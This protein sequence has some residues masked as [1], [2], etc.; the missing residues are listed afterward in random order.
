[1]RAGACAALC[2]LVGC[3]ALEGLGDLT[4]DGGGGGPS[5]ALAGDDCNAPPPPGWAGPVALYEGAPGTLPSC[6]DVYSTPVAQGKRGATAPPAQCGACACGPAAVTC[7]PGSLDVFWKSSC[8][9]GS[10]TVDLPGGMCTGVPGMTGM[11]YSYGVAAPSVT[12]G[13]APSGGVPSLPATAWTTAGIACAPA[14]PPVTCAEG[15]VCS[16]PPPAPFEPRWCVWQAG[17][18]AC[19]AAFPVPHLWETAD[20]QRG[21]SPCACDPPSTTCAVTTT[22]FSS[23]A[24][25][26]AGSP[27]ATLSGP[28]QCIDATDVQWAHAGV[29]LCGPSSCKASGGV[30]VGQVT[31]ATATTI[32]CPQ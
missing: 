23:Q 19:P 13:C 27:A 9:G 17:A 14:G 22:L 32:C 21:C 28:G 29:Q 11:V 10:T 30:P 31:P 5:C 18:H 25:C 6:P 7:S 1:M 3:R 16:P 24:A 2:A 4:F 12:G 26:P 8:H 20:D 15:S